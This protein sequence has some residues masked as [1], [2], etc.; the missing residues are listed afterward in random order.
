MREHQDSTTNKSVENR[1]KLGYK[2]GYFVP[3]SHIEN[4]KSYKYV[5]RPMVALVGREQRTQYTNLQQF[6]F[7]LTTDTKVKIA[8]WCQSI[9]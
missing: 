6:L 7:S 9:F 5:K 1:N 4:L 2:M 3:D 8:R